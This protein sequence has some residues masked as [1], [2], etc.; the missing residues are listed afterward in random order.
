[1][2][3][4]LC[5]TLCDP[6]DCGPPG[7]SVYGILQARILEWVAMPSS[8]G[9]FLMQGSNPL[10]LCLLHWQVGSLTLA[11]P[12][13]GTANNNSSALM[14]DLKVDSRRGKCSA[15][16]I[17]YPT[18]FQGVDPWI[19]SPLPLINWPPLSLAGWLGQC[20]GNSAGV[21][22]TTH[23]L[24]SCALV[25]VSGF[26]PC[27]CN[28]FWIPG[29]AVCVFYDPTLQPQI[30]QV[31]IEIAPRPQSDLETQQ[32]IHWWSKDGWEVG[33]MEWGETG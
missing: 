20:S 14:K 31:D 27:S 33:G 28:I 8:R 11:P 3:A 30:L 25:S 29:P 17:L 12:V 23:F 9:I 6:M 18:N 5:L 22:L 32:C 19:F 24:S 26:S 10:L 16:F 2:G 13:S 7:S 21:A 4:Q 1:M 15:S